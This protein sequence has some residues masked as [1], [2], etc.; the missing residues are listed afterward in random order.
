M[1]TGRGSRSGLYKH[2]R[3]LY[4]GAAATTGY[5]YLEAEVR[6][7]VPNKEGALLRSACTAD[8]KD[9][10]GSTMLLSQMATELGFRGEAQSWTAAA[11]ALL[12]RLRDVFFVDGGR[13]GFFS[14][15]YFNGSVATLVSKDNKFFNAHGYW[16]GYESLAKAAGV[17]SAGS[18]ALVRRA[19]VGMLASAYGLGVSAPQLS[20]PQ[21]VDQIP[22][23][24]K[25]PLWH[26]QRITCTWAKENWGEQRRR[27]EA[28]RYHVYCCQKPGLPEEAEAEGSGSGS[29]AGEAETGEEPSAPVEE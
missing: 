17:E 22:R 27:G 25:H 3:R 24:C 23:R 11:E 4:E 19:V 1:P 10:A 29:A 8:V 21:K 28:P 13:A 16:K 15:V 14:D 6:Y 18:L 7:A 5:P 9:R 20:R 12:P 26:L 2:Y